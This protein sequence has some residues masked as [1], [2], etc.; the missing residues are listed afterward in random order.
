MCN[1][2]LPRFFSWFEKFEELH[3]FFVGCLKALNAPQKLHA[4]LPHHLLALS[5]IKMWQQI[6]FSCVWI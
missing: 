1:W 4:I 3:T 6:L 2:A 5:M